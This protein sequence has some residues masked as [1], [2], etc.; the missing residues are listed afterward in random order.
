MCW[1]DVRF[2]VDQ[3]KVGIAGARTVCGPNGERDGVP[4]RAKA[5]T[6]YL[7]RCALLRLWQSVALLRALHLDV[8]GF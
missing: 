1:C 2:V 6:Q 5:L 4:A 3:R 8:K 7:A